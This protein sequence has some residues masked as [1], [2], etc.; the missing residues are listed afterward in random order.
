MVNKYLAF[1]GSS[2]KFD[3]PSI[4]NFNINSLNNDTNEFGVYFLYMRNTGAKTDEQL[5]Y[6]KIKDYALRDSSKGYVY[7]YQL[8]TELFN[9]KLLKTNDKMSFED[10]Y[11]LFRGYDISEQTIQDYYNH[12][13]S[14][15]N[16]KLIKIAICFYK[17]VNSN[18]SWE[19]IA[20]ELTA[21]TGKNGFI[22]GNT[23][24]GTIVLW[25]PAFYNSVGEL[26][27]ISR[28]QVKRI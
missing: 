18:I 12:Q 24:F 5:F 7:K 9:G 11:E 14:T 10:F 1:H 20:H 26:E 6:R 19:N 3:Y 13:S 23:N 21:R 16:A 28:K 25:N 17:V 22:N 4:N 27:L 2:E 8:N 15:N